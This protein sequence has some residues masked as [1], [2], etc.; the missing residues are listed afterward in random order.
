MLRFMYYERWGSSGQTLYIAY[1]MNWILHFI[2]KLKVE[3]ERYM[4]RTK[5]GLPTLECRYGLD[6]AAETTHHLGSDFLWRPS[7]PV[8]L[9]LLSGMGGD[10]A[11]SQCRCCNFI[12]DLK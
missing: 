11:E 9:S 5:K 8:V 1:P 4:K 7:D 2:P 3:C 6:M 12:A 10:I